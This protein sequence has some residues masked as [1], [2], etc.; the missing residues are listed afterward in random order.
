[1]SNQL[2]WRKSSYSG[3]GGGDCA[4]V[5]R[6]PESVQVRDSKA[7]E[8]ARLAVAPGAWSAIPPTVVGASSRRSHRRPMTSGQSR[9]GPVISSPMVKPLAGP[10]GMVTSVP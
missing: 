8:R 10:S 2:T 3:S 4:E 7:A 6:R 9:G 1:V 5:A